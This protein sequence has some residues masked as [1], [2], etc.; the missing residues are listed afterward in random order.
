MLISKRGAQKKTKGNTKC[1][2]SSAIASQ[3]SIRSPIGMRRRFPSSS[4]RMRVGRHVSV[5][6]L[7]ATT[8]LVETDESSAVAKGGF[9]SFRLPPSLSDT[10]GGEANVWAICL[11]Y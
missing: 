5:R 7:L 3:E 8:K 9:T 4:I 1:S 6:W 10:M 11:S 2:V